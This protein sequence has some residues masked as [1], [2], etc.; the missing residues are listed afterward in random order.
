LLPLSEE[1]I[2]RAIELNGAAVEANK[3]AFLWGRRTA[4]DAA[5]VLALLGPQKQTLPHRKPSESLDETIAR[6]ANF[7]T[8]YQNAAL[9]N[10]YTALVDKVRAAE[11]RIAP[12]RED[13]TTAVA[14]AWFKLLAYKDEYEV[15]RLFT[16][17]TFDTALAEQFQGERIKMRF[18][19]A[20][21]LLAPRDALGNARKVEIGGWIKGPFKLLAQ[22]KALRGTPLDIFG[23]TAERKL[24][25]RLIADYEAL[26]GELLAAL[27][28]GNHAIAVELAA[29]PLTM[30][31]FG[32]VLMDNVDKAKAREAKLLADF[33]APAPPQPLAAE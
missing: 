7:L 32:H 17:G 22:F 29:L 24:Q 28:G 27:N 1:A 5:A 4:H 25:R 23:Y 2:L 3:Q 18:H 10:R 21:P 9:A 12:G 33:K 26:I 8:G 14:K 30:R 20:P 6:R 19:L 13:L 11:S 15:A 31:G 16:D